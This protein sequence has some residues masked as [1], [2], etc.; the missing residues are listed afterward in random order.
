[1]NGLGSEMKGKFAGPVDPQ[2][3]LHFFLPFE[4]GKLPRMPKR[5]KVPFQRVADQTAEPAMYDPMVCPP[6]SA[7][8]IYSYDQI[9][10]LKR[11][12]PGFDLVDTH[13]HPDKSISANEPEIKPDVSSGCL[14]DPTIITDI[15][16]IDV[17]M[18]FKKDPHDDPF[19]DPESPPDNNNQDDDDSFLFENN[20]AA[21]FDTMGQI[22]CYA[23]QQLATQFRT[24]AFSVLICKGSS[25]G[26]VRVPSLRVPF[27]MCRSRGWQFFSGDIPTRHQQ[28]VELMNLSPHLTTPT[29]P[30]FRKQ[31]PLSSSMMKRPC[32]SLRST[33]RRRGGCFLLFW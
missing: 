8:C 29:R 31:E 14:V 10:A 26:I 19:L 1:M 23:T 21:S 30:M 20:T 16:R 17:V 7:C 3:F 6:V 5:M 11:Y 18:E 13:S 25:I 12:C 28:H 32:T 24:H 15:S 33:G 2:E 27:H 4:R 9:K 22:T